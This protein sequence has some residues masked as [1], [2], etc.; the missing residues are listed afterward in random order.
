MA[1]DEGLAQRLR[2]LFQETPGVTEKK[3]FGGLVFL[4]NGNMCVGVSSRK[5]L[6]VRVGP[7]SFEAA[8]ERPQVQPMVHGGKTMKGFLFVAAEAVNEDEV[9]TYWV[10]LSRAWVASLPVK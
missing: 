7:E 1:F 8:L 2:E 6:L 4:L 10:D 3:M 5:A 9:L